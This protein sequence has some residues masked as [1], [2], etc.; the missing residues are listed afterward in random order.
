MK[1]ELVLS[2]ALLL[3]LSACSSSKNEYEKAIA[4]YVQTDRHGTWTDCKFQALSI[5]QIA[6]ITVAD[7]LKLLQTEFEKSRDEQIASQQR[8][9]DYFNSLLK[10]NQ[11][12]KYAK[13]TVDEQLSQNIAT[14][15]A[16]IDSLRNL[17]AVYADRFKGRN[18][19]EVLVQKIKC[20]Y[21][22]ILPGS[23]REQERVEVFI[24]T[25]DGKKVLMKEKLEHL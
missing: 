13:Q 22:Y 2:F 11:S 21:S 4:D 8:T 3:L 10:D 23:D 7:S 18:S 12:A 6:N 20:N 25:P 16:R 5:E 24:M 14:A 9:L 17:P 19:T 1:R 15:Q